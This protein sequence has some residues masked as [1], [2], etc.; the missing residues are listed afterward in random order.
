MKL[1]DVFY[2]P[3]ARGQST[4]DTARHLPAPSGGIRYARSSWDNEY[5]IPDGGR[6]RA[7]SRD[8]AVTR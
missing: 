8:E 1:Y 2:K 5:L 4:F 3:D 7:V 6:W